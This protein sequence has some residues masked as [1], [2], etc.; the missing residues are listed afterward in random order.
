M[1]PVVPNVQIMKDNFKDKSFK[2]SEA[3]FIFF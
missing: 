2:A 3:F 1:F